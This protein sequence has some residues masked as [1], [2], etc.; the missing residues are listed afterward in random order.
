MHYIINRPL[1]DS[2]R[3]TIFLPENCMKKSAYIYQIFKKHISKLA[4]LVQK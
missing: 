2:A 1:A 4:L 3:P